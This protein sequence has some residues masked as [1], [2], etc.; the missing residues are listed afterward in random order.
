[1]KSSVQLTRNLIKPLFLRYAGFFCIAA[2]FYLAIAPYLELT[3]K[4]H[5]T[6]LITI[7]IECVF[8]LIVQIILFIV[9]KRNVLS[10]LITVLMYLGFI[11]SNLI[12]IKYLNAPLYPS[13]FILA[14]DLIRTWELFKQFI[15]YLI[16]VV[17]VILLV[18]YYGFKLEKPH[19]K[20][21]LIAK[22]YLLFICVLSIFI[23]NFDLRNDLRQSNLY[24]RKNANLTKNALKFGFLNNFLVSSVFHGKPEPPNNYNLLAIK[25]IVD[26][27]AL[28]DNSD[29]ESVKPDNVVVL[30][31][32]AFTNP[33]DFGWKF[34][35]NPVPTFSSII[36]NHSH[37]FVYSPVYGGKSINA[38]YELMTGMSTN[39]IPDE[40]TPYREFIDRNIPGMARTFRE[41][42]YVTWVL[43]AGFRVKRSQIRRN[44]S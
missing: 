22:I 43:G 12:K 15:P 7:A 11:F 31:V 1:M 19:K 25:K 42:G 30:L 5:I 44:H 27:H 10:F 13:D 33:H 16:L 34:T 4:S 9:S 28:N 40:S 35:S 17:L 24:F 29:F 8:L 18:F 6:K 14:G 26:K 37:G 2:L 32:E 41:N 23:I 21:A 36:E 39:F 3:E 38:E 20:H